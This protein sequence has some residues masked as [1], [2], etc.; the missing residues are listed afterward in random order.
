MLSGTVG[1]LF[2]AWFGSCRGGEGRSRTEPFSPSVAVVVFWYE[3]GELS[4]QPKPRP[5][6]IASATTQ[7]TTRAMRRELNTLL[8]PYRPQ[9]AGDA[10]ALTGDGCSSFIPGPSHV[11][12][13]GRTE[14]RAA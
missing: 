6:P 1:A 3:L 14:I 11:K 8:Y 10:P 12:E 7:A 5:T 2:G 4:P 9:S 13:A